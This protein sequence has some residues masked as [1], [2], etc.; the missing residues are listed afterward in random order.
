MLFFSFYLQNR[1]LP[2]TYKNFK[3][4]GKT[5]IVAQFFLIYGLHLPKNY[6]EQ[7]ILLPPGLAK[8]RLESDG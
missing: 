5:Y 8:K 2:S 3:V 6:R 1:R 4:E 7:A